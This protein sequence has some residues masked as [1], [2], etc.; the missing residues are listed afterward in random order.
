MYHTYKSL[1]NDLPTMDAYDR[2]IAIEKINELKIKLY[3]EERREKLEAITNQINE[4]EK[5]IAELKQ[6]G[7]DLINEYKLDEKLV[8][9]LEIYLFSVFMK[10]TLSVAFITTLPVMPLTNNE[11]ENL[12][13]FENSTLNNYHHFNY[14]NRYKYQYPYSLYSSSTYYE[15]DYD[16]SDIPPEYYDEMESN[17]INLLKESNAD[18]YIFN[19]NIHNIWI[20][21]DEDKIAFSLRLEY[22]VNNEGTLEEQNDYICFSLSQNE[23]SILD[24]YL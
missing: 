9:D 17:I 7:N 21:D 22:Y 6:A 18:K 20:L 15:D 19:Y 24:L 10:S 11:G 12:E 16:Y 3:E 2:T 4:C 23:A 1:L 14:D 13:P 8:D 5:Q